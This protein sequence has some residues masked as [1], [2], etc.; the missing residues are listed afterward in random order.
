MKAALHK[1]RAGGYNGKGQ[2]ELA[3]ADCNKV[4]EFYSNYA[5]AF[6]TR[7][8]AY[9]GLGKKALAIADFKMLITLSDDPELI[10]IAEQQ[11]EEL[12]K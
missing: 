7:G 9:K 3:I 6:K 5:E 12:S 4:I 1:N 2:Y 10:E 8:F 11:I